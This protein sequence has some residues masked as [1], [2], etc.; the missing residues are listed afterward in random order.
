MASD[1]VAISNGD[2]GLTARTVLNT[3]MTRM[4]DVINVKDWGA[5]GNGSTDDTAALQAALDSAYGTSG[6]PHGDSSKYTNKGVFFPNGNYK[7]TSP[8]TI[9]SATG[10]WIAGAGRSSTN[11]FNA[12][13]NGSVFVTNG[14]QY[15]RVE[16]LS[17][18][19]NGN[20]IAFDLD[21]DNTGSAALQ[22]NTFSQILL[23]G[24]LF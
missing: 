16:G 21:W 1:L 9:R 4:Q 7:I 6:S 14:F 3:M 5:V 18:S 12:T 13:A 17:L 20:G 11:I 24:R 15:S 23:L 8:L 19:A 10:A 22:A 2:S